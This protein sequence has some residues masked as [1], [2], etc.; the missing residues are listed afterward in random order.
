MWHRGS[1]TQGLE[2]SGRSL[3]L[4][5]HPPVTPKWNHLRGRLSVVYGKCRVF[6]CSSG[7]PNMNPGSIVL[8]ASILLA[9][10]ADTCGSCSSSCFQ[11]CMMKSF[12]RSLMDGCSKERVSCSF[13]VPKS[14]KHTFFETGPRKFRSFIRSFKRSFVRSS[15]GSCIWSFIRSLVK[16][17]I[18]SL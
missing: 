4:V 16:S 13:W 10:W 15:F 18:R 5:T 6:P 12:I 11:T 1:G 17:F 2:D 14:S 7:L 9:R 3:K 8:R